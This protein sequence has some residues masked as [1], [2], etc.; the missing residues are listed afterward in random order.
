MNFIHV[1]FPET[2]R[3]LF[4][5]P[6]EGEEFTVFSGDL[7]MVDIVMEVGAFP[8]R[9]QARNNGWDKPIPKGFSAHKVGKRR[10]WVLNEFEYTGDVTNV[11]D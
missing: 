3:E 7:N 4:F 5:G 2:D 1:S 11:E 9:K 10:F 8:S 6:L